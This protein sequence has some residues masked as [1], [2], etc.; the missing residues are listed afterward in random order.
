MIDL[1]EVY[2][3]TDF[4]RRAKEHLRRLKRTGKPQVLTVNGRAVAVVQ[5]AGAY[6]TL[7]D[8]IDQADAQA[9]I[10]RG[11]DAMKR[12]RVRP[13]KQFLGDLKAKHERPRR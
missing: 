9:G 13:F 8:A 2:P 12:G 10:R 11:I 4:Q 1:A 5:D 6:Q 7:V 3:L